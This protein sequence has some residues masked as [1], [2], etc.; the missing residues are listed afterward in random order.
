M[1]RLVGAAFVPRHP[2]RGQFLLYIRVSHLSGTKWHSL[3]FLALEQRL[4]QTI[5]SRYALCVD[6]S[7]KRTGKPCDRDL[8][9]IEV[10]KGR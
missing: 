7:L 2:A 3:H 6:I 9:L 1:Q 5:C 4:W 10:V 8:C